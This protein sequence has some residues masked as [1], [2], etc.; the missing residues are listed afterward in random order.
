MLLKVK[1]QFIQLPLGEPLTACDLQNIDDCLVCLTFRGKPEMLLCRWGWKRK[2]DEHASYQGFWMLDNSKLP[3]Y[4]WNTYGTNWQAY[5][6][7]LPRDIRDIAVF[8][9]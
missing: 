2:E 3:T 6:V 9:G 8:A 4:P 7:N 5:R 1:Q